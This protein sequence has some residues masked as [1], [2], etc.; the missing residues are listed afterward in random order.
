[1]LGSW[2]LSTSSSQD[3][4][5]LKC[6][7]NSFHNALHLS[8]EDPEW[9]PWRALSRLHSGACPPTAPFSSIPEKL[10]RLFIYCFWFCLWC[11]PLPLST[12]EFFK[13][14]KKSYLLRFLVWPGDNL[15]QF[16]IWLRHQ[17]RHRCKG[18]PEM[19]VQLLR[20]VGR[21]ERGVEKG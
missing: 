8:P 6:H 9:R 19:K 16:F 2:G 3:I 18:F 17:Q 7:R 14:W 4:Q 1:M 15:S 11:Q 21:E 20:K 13:Y 5:S 10:G 12:Q